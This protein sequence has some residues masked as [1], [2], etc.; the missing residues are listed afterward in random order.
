[1]QELKV[2]ALEYF[3][4]WRD[5]VMGRVGEAVNERTE[6]TQQQ[7]LQARPTEHQLPSNKKLDDTKNSEQDAVSALHELNPPRSTTL[8]EL[9]Q[10]QRVLILHSLLLLLLSLE[11]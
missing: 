7:K 11:R 3:D 6:Q 4:E 8:T 10:P 1:M 5:R 2:A 9:P